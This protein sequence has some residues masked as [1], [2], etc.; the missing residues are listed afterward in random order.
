MSEKPHS[1]RLL[2]LFNLSQSGSRKNNR[3]A[4]EGASIEPTRPRKEKCLFILFVRKLTLIEVPV[5]LPKFPCYLS[6][7]FVTIKRLAQRMTGQSLNHFIL[8]LILVKTVEQFCATTINKIKHRNSAS[9]ENK[10][11]LFNQAYSLSQIST[12]AFR[13]LPDESFVSANWKNKLNPTF[14]HVISETVISGGQ[15]P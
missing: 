7:N 8:A 15:P 1:I 12:H 5:T 6:L 9:E 2:R 3:K 14:L 10:N 11:F 13:W 4:F